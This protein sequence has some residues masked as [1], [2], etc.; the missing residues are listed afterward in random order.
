MEAR[1][2]QFIRER[3]YLGNVTP[4]TIEWYRR[5]LKWLPSDAPTQ[6][7]LKATLLRMR[8][9]AHTHNGVCDSDSRLLCRHCPWTSAY[10]FAFISDD[11]VIWEI[12]DASYA[13]ST[14]FRVAK[15]SAA[16]VDGILNKLL[17]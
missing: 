16:D 13:I 10:C 14:L 1:F 9:D 2:E 3:Q 7:D 4:S 11:R 17:G 12:W 8:K 6:D 5:C 15:E